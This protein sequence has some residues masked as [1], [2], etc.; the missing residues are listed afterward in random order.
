MLW[1]G[2]T[3]L[4]VSLPAAGA[5]GEAESTGIIAG[6]VRR[7]TWWHEAKFGMFIHFG[8]FSVPFRRWLA[9]TGA[10]LAS[11]LR[12][13]DPYRAADSVI[14]SSPSAATQFATRSVG[15]LA[16]HAQQPARLSR[17][18]RFP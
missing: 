15:A 3:S 9:T 1:L 11:M 5:A 10:G 16:E 7:M 12:N 14:G 4:A 17:G 18:E 2:A 6:R 8:L 13:R